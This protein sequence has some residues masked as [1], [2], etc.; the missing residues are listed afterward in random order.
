MPDVLMGKYILKIYGLIKYPGMK[1]SGVFFIIYDSNASQM[2]YH[3][4]TK[5]IY[6]SLEG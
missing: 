4:F 3:V 6:P 5:R 2:D 1:T